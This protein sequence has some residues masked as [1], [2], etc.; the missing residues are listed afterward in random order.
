MKK[1][2]IEEVRQ[3]AAAILDAAGIVITPAERAAMEVADCG[4]GDLERLGLQVVLYAN[5]PRYCAK[6]I[7]LLPRQM[8]PEHLHPP[9]DA[10]NIG[11]QETFR[12]RWGQ[13]YLYIPGEPT[14]DPQAKVPEDYRPYLT[15]WREVILNPGDQWTLDPETKHWFQAGDQGAVVSEFSSTSLDET[16]VFTDPRVDRIP[17]EEP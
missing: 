10:G 13:L 7:I 15:V 2:I 6:E 1:S 5:N 4:F 12:C 11:K 3:K 8:F 9:I 14:P 17:R 16:D